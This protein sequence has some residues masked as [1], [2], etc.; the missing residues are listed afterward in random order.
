VNKFFSLHFNG[1]FSRWTWVSRYQIVSSVDFIRAMDDADGGDNVN[2]HCIV[3]W[4]LNTGDA[5]HIRCLWRLN[6][7]LD[8]SVAACT[9]KITF[10]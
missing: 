1:D 2:K 9:P 8:L 5:T 7:I 3:I 4:I 10:T 6:Y